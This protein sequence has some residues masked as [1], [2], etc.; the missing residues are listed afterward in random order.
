MKILLNDIGKKYNKQWI[1][2]N[3]QYT[4][5]SG[6]TIAIL[7]NN[8]SGKST[9]LQCIMGAIQLTTGSITYSSNNTTIN[10]TTIYKHISYASPFLELIEEFTLFEM[11]D[12]HSKFK[13]LYPDLT[14]ALIAEAVGLTNA[15]HKPIAQYSSGMKQ[16]LKL[17]LAFFSQSNLL[18]LDEP[19][20]NLDSNGLETYNLLVKNYLYNRTV[21]ISSNDV[22]EYSFCAQKIYLA[23]YKL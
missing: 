16:R 6:S 19:L 23:D 17:A 2:N 4:I 22:N 10:D 1:F 20:S 8:G 14:T 5:E 7:G 9:L 15:I 12:F 21:L 11:V 3:L 13:P 18:C